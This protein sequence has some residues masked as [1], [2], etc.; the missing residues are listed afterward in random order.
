MI[1]GKFPAPLS[2]AANTLIMLYLH[3][4]TVVKM[5]IQVVVSIDVYSTCSK[6]N[7]FKLPWYVRVLQNIS[8]EYL[9]ASTT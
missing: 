6:S 9:F 5:Q 4:C 1:Y 8:T 7:A 3:A 2:I